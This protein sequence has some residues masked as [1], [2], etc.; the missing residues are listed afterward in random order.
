MAALGNRDKRPQGKLVLGF[1]KE[2]LAE[3][4]RRLAEAKLPRTKVFLKQLDRRG[5]IEAIRGPARPGRLQRQYRLAIEEGLPEVIADNLLADAGSALAPTLQV[6]LTKMWERAR[7]ANPDQPRF[8]RDLYESLKSEGYLLKDVL[9]VGLKAIG[10]WNP[11]AE[12]SGLALDVLLYHTT[13]LGTS[14]Q[15]TRA[16]LDRRYA[17]RVDVLDGLLG[18]CKDNYMLIEAEPHPES[19]TRSTRLAHD[20]LA[21]LVQ[22]RFRLSVAPGQRARRLLENRAPEWHDGK[23]GPVLD[24]T[25][26]ASIEDGASGMRIW[27]ADEIRLVDAS[28]RAEAQRQADENERGRRVRAAEENRRLAEARTRKTR[29]IAA[30]VLACISVVLAIATIWAVRAQRNADDRA[31]IVSS[32]QLAALA[33]GE[34]DDHEIDRALLLDVHAIGLHSTSAARSILYETLTAV[35]GKRTHV[36]LA[37]KIANDPNDK[38]KSKYTIGSTAYQEVSDLKFSPDGTTLA[39]SLKRSTYS[40]FPDGIILWDVV[41]NRP[42]GKPQKSK[43]DIEAPR[44]FTFSPDGTTLADCSSIGVVQWRVPGHGLL[45]D[46]RVLIGGPASCIAYSHDGK[47]L[48][49]GFSEGREGRVVLWEVSS[50]GSLKKPSVV[51]KDFGSPRFGVDCESLDF[52]PD[53]KMLIAGFSLKEVPDVR[54]RVVLWGISK[55]GAPQE[56]FDNG[57]GDGGVAF[58]PDSSRVLAGVRDGVTIYQTKKSASRGGL[59]SPLGDLEITGH[60]PTCICVSGRGATLAV[61]SNKGVALWDIVN[62]GGNRQAAARHR[63]RRKCPVRRL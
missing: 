19:P 16:A 47:H 11:V 56:L 63:A 35:P 36:P 6:L 18:R 45:S 21:P 13:E 17:H 59:G 37:E 14:S 61:G 7:Q 20:L 10:R 51:T 55:Q 39:A 4:D 26:L 44:R 8:D 33:S 25:D 30:I 15:R 46:P 62:L 38:D 52:S 43:N 49:A 40:T 41:G 2:W 23:I 9:D 58:D 54:H 3:L 31:R 24:S 48:A 34:L 5:I 60:G 57:G 28:R 53:G 27:T 29:G 42:F 50:E 32:R 22:Q 12:E 1:R